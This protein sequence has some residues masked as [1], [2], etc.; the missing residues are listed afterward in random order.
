MRGGHTSDGGVRIVSYLLWVGMGIAC[1]VSPVPCPEVRAEELKIGYVDMAKV[2]DGYYRTKAFDAQLE[3][4]G[5][6]KETELKNRMEHL[7]KL[8]QSLELLSDQAREAREREIEEKSD[9]LQRFRTMTT[10]DLRREREKVAGQVFKEIEQGI[11][12]YANANGLTLI[13]DRRSLLYGQP[14][15]DVSDDVLN[16]LNSRSTTKQ[17]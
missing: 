15:R 7:R 3:T 2:F 10:R 14:G 13:L 6:Q 11:T 8:R 5:K 12:D 16:L 4:L 17:P 9:E 1:P